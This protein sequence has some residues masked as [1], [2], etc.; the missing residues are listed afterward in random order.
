M[1]MPP[2]A[3]GAQVRAAGLAARA[4]ELLA[5]WRRPRSR[6]TALSLAMRAV[7]RLPICVAVS[8]IV[9]LALRRTALIAVRGTA[10]RTVAALAAATEIVRRRSVTRRVAR[11][12]LRGRIVARPVRRTVA[13]R[14]QTMR[15]LRRRVLP[16]RASVQRWGAA[17]AGA[18]VEGAAALGTSSNAP[19]SH[20]G[21]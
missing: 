1:F 13:A 20:A 16:A 14:S 7:W 5:E 8:A 15:A 9:T 10:S 3:I 4:A 2:E 12:A 21:P 18:P 6:R 19:A 17:G 11:R